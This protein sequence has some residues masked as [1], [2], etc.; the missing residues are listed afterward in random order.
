MVFNK[1]QLK[2]YSS[3]K[4]YFVDQIKPKRLIFLLFPPNSKN[5]ANLIHLNSKKALT[6]MLKANY[7]Y[8]DGLHKK[9]YLDVL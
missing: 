6:M 2:L 8:L 9:Q 5:K 7:V 1:K 4:K 3:K